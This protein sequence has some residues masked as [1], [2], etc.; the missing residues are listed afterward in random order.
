MALAQIGRNDPRLALSAADCES[1][2]PLAAQWLARGVSDA[3]LINALTSSLP[4]HIGSPFGLTR[5]RLMEKM[6]PALPPAPPKEA[7]APVRRRMPECSECGIPGPREALIDGMC[8]FCRTGQP[9]A[10]RTP[11]APDVDVRARIGE[12][13]SLL[14]SGGTVSAERRV[15]S[16][17]RQVS[18]GRR[19]V[20]PAPGPS[21]AADDTATVSAAVTHDDG[22]AG[23]GVEN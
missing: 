8:H 10:P 18:E 13:R 1:L 15:R 2:E 9:P 16:R 22:G 23:S 12:V 11:P 5:K 6:P 17:K 20:P 3:Y 14:R 19:D 21:P 4:S 7:D